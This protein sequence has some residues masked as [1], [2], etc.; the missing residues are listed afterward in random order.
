[1]YVGH[2]TN[3]NPSICIQTRR[4]KAFSNTTCVTACQ[5]SFPSPTAKRERPLPL[6][7]LPGRPTSAER[8][9][10]TVIIEIGLTTEGLHFVPLINLTST[11][12][13]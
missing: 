3:N 1:M 7:T 9:N 8:A 2:I 4:L 5:F 11:K 12:P 6:L 13:T 10:K